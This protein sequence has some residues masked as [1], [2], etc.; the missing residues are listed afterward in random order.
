MSDLEKLGGLEAAEQAGESYKEE[1]PDG[2]PISAINEVE[3]L[4]D[5]REALI[6]RVKELER[7]LAYQID[8]GSQAEIA[9]THQLQSARELAKRIINFE[10]TV[11]W[12]DDSS[13]ALETLAVD[14]HKFLEGK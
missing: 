8:M 12:H 2:W 14:A 3:M 7:E 10:K 11:T 13:R 1:Y 5:F 4:H 6:A 9:F